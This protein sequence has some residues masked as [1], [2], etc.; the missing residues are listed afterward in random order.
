MW[1]AIIA[2]AGCPFGGTGVTARNA[3]L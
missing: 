1:G 3:F 2:Q